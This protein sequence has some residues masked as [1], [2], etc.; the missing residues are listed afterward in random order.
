MVLNGS[1]HTT[2]PVS[3]TA[4]HWPAYHAHAIMPFLLDGGSIADDWED[5][6]GEGEYGGPD[7]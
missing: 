7:L 2:P 5:G 4:A 1:F 6:E 3:A